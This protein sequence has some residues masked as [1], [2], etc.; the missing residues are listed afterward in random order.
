MKAIQISF[1]SLLVLTGHVFAQDKAHQSIAVTQNKTT[2]LIFQNSIKS[3]DR[4][5]PD[6]LAQKAKGVENVLQ[7]KAGKPTFLETNVTVITA[8]GRLHQFS[9]TYTENPSA[10]TFSVNSNGKI[11]DA[12]KSLV[13][14]GTDMTEPQMEAAAKAMIAVNTRSRIKKSHSNGI[15]LTLTSIGIRGGSMFYSLNITNSSNIGYDIQDIRLYIRDKAKMKRTASQEVEVKPLYMYGQTD[16]VQGSSSSSLVFVLEKFT[17]PDSKRF[18]I[19]ITEKNGG[20]HLTLWI[21]NG[22]IVKAK[23]I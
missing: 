13:I 9:V 20:R 5:S 6:V 21:K 8:D 16:A 17:I 10:M 11:H 15:A 23:Q 4:G 22:Q 18:V 3:V 14:L 2:S 19:E 12:N 7:L 1:L